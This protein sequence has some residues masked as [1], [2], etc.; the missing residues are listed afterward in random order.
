MADFSKYGIDPAKD[1]KYENVI[2]VLALVYEEYM[3][4]VSKHLARYKLSPTKFN[5]LMIVEYQGGKDGISQVAIGER[6]IVS[7]GN[8]TGLVERLVRDGLLT[9]EQN[10]NNRRENIIRTTPKAVE[11]IEEVWPGY[12]DLV[13]KLTD[14]VPAKEQAH[15][16]KVFERWLEGIRAQK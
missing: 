16:G 2:Y 8:I 11:L 10:P 9:R 6:L 12:D 15:L 7:A 14:I 4:L 5:L 13:R 3:A 1:R